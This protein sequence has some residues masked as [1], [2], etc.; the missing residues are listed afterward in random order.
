MKRLKFYYVDLDSYDKSGKYTNFYEFY[1]FDFENAN[2][3]FK[4]IAE[5]Q[6]NILHKQVFDEAGRP[7]ENSTYK[8]GYTSIS[9][10]MEFNLNFNCFDDFYNHIFYAREISENDAKIIY[11]KFENAK[12]DHDIQ[13]IFDDSE[14]DLCIVDFSG[15]SNS[16]IILKTL[17]ADGTI[18]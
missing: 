8:N 6:K 18:L 10:F 3:K 5:N 4:E 7:L 2:K 15:P 11:E 14:N 16:G 9:I 12:T 17:Y 1:F 13:E